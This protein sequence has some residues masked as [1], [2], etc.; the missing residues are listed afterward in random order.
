MDLVVHRNR[1]SKGFLESKHTIFVTTID[2]LAYEG[3]WGVMWYPLNTQKNCFCL[4]KHIKISS[5]VGRVMLLNPH[6]PGSI[7]IDNTL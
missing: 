7:A 2:R 1:R 6:D 3:E 4:K 5:I